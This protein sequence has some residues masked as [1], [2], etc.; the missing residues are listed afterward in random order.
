VLTAAPWAP[1]LA[2]PL[3]TTTDVDDAMCAHAYTAEACSF[4]VYEGAWHLPFRSDGSHFVH[5]WRVLCPDH[6]YQD[7]RRGYDDERAAH[8]GASEHLSSAH[9]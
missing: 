1:M 5:V 8:E 7:P 9:S 3:P 4:V 6:S 2:P